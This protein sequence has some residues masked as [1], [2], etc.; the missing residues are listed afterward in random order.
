MELVSKD[1][2]KKINFKIS[3][4]CNS[5]GKNNVLIHSDIS[6]LGIFN[7]INK[8]QYLISHIDNINNIFYD[9]NIWMPSFNYDYCETRIYDIKNDPVS[10][11][12]LNDFYKNIAKWRT[13][14]PVFSMS[15]NGAYPVK[16]YVNG[17]IINPFG[18]NS[19]FDYLYKTNSLYCHYGSNIGHTTLIH[20]VEGICG[21]LLYRYKKLFKGSVILDN[22]KI[23]ITLNYHVRPIN[24]ILDFD[25]KKIYNDL[26]KNNLIVNFK[27][28]NNVNYITLFSVKKVVDY[29]LI[30][31]D[32]DPFY[33]LNEDS[34]SWLIPK[35]EKLGRG[36]LISDFE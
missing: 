3:N 29:W 15:G 10:V 5:F 22:N 27:I 19:E 23:D 1:D 21:N 26:D 11:G 4:I 30:K 17:D 32:K 14:T 34:K 7:F 12:V 20:Y 2:L 13:E 9:Y 35:V 33:F 24:H 36:F 16:K 25:I 31:L 6:S 18:F 28:D 8:K